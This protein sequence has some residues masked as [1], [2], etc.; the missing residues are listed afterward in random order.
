MTQLGLK[1]GKELCSTHLK[2][3]LDKSKELGNVI[4]IDMKSSRYTQGTIDWFSDCLP[5][6][7]HCVIPAYLYRSHHDICSLAPI[8]CNIRLCK[9]AY[10][11]VSNVA[12]PRRREVEENFVK[13]LQTLLLSPSYTAVATHD[14]TIISRSKR[15]VDQHNVGQGGACGM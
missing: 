15:L 1:T 14:E 12:F 6:Q 11:E 7:G 2:A 8:G 4:R 10:M 3:I 13:L 9:G 5:V